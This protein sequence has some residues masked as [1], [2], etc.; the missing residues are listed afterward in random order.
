VTVDPGLYP[1]AVA[2]IADIGGGHQRPTP[3][4]S[5]DPRDGNDHARERFS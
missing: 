2:E 4:C 1:Q 5:G 3:R